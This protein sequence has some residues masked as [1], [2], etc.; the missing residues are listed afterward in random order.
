MSGEQ[1]RYEST[2]GNHKKLRDYL[3]N[4]ANTASADEF[5]L[6]PLMYAVWN[7]HVE[8]VK[9]LICNDVGVDVR[10][11]KVSALH[12]RSCKGYTALHLAA[13]DAPKSSAK[14]ITLLLLVAGLDR[15]WLCDEGST[16]EDYA[17][18]NDCEQ[19]LLAF[20]EFDDAEQ[21]TKILAELDRIRKTLLENYT[22]IH[23]PTMNVEPAK[24]WRESKR[25]EI[26]G[27]LYDPLHVG[28]IPE[29]MKIHEHQLEPLR[30]EGYEAV[31]DTVQALQVLDFS[32]E[33]AD[34]NQMR[35]AK[36][37]SAGD[38]DKTWEPADL[39]QLRADKARAV[40][41]AHSPYERRRR[42]EQRVLAKLEHEQAAIETEM[43]ELVEE[44]ARQDEEERQRL[45]ELARRKAE[46]EEMMSQK[47]KLDKDDA[48]PWLVKKRF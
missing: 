31:K 21:D 39:G 3:K 1:L 22:F 8:C 34:A 37:I 43:R 28:A 10:G 29:G 15:T 30:Q 2:Y 46:H 45:E 27:F 33:Q 12:M 25:F 18:A 24:M 9:Y 17:R 42:K 35:R 26:P 48:E 5:G 20:Q 40:I 7:G 23:N 38:S 47:L 36:L 41:R 19:S 13:L 16:P 44:Q 4:R 14:E 32:V 11:V 6:T